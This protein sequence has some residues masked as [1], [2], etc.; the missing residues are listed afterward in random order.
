MDKLSKSQRS[1]L[2]SR[3]KCRGTGPELALGRIMKKLGVWHVAHPQGLPGNPDFKVIAGGRPLAVF[4][5]GCFFHKCP[6]HFRLPKSRSDHWAEHIRKNVV[7]HRRNA[8]ALRRLGFRVAVVWEH[9]L[10][11]KKSKKLSEAR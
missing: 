3:I 4:V 8:A 2:M 5:H 10:P 6:A 9:E 11:R 7:R 1:E